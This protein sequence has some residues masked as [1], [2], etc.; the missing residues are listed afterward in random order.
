MLDPPENC[1]LTYKIE[2]ISPDFGGSNL[3]DR[4]I[5][6]QNVGRKL[7]GMLGIREQAGIAGD[8]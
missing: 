8:L 3:Q 7:L 2:P 4:T 1:D 5:D 6:K